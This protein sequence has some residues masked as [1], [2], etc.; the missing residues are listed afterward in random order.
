MTVQEAMEVFGNALATVRSFTYPCEYT[1]VGALSVTRDVPFRKKGGR[2]EEF[3][4]VEAPA[5]RAVRELQVYKPRR[6]FLCSI[7]P[8]GKSTTD[9][10]HDYKSYGF[11]LLRAEAFMVRA[12][13]LPIETVAHL[14]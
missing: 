12:L 9:S 6:F 8:Q 1:H 14:D 13:S 2:V 7:V 3:F 5:K 4:A 11:R 10:K